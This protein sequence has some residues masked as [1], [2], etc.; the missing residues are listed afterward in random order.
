VHGG[1]LALFSFGS[2]DEGNMNVPPGLADIISVDGSRSGSLALLADGSIVQWGNWPQSPPSN[3]PKVVEI[4]AGWAWA[5]VRLSDGSLRG[6]GANDSG[7]VSGIPSG[8]DF[9]EIATGNMHGLA[10]RA[11]GTVVSWG[12]NDMGQTI[13]PQGLNNVVSISAHGH[14]CVALKS[15]GTVVGWGN[16]NSGINNVPA[17][18][19]NVKA[20]ACGDIFAL[21][22][23]TDGTVVAWGD[24]TEGQTSIPHG[25]KNVAKI[26][27]EGNTAYAILENGSLTS[28]G[29][30]ANE[31]L[32]PPKLPSGY[33]W[34]AIRG[35][36]EH[37]HGL[38]EMTAF[39]I[40]IPPSINGSV[41]GSGEYEPATPATLTAIP[42]PGY[43]FTGWTGDAS[44]TDNPLTITMDADKTV[45]ATF[46][47]DLSDDDG[48]GLSNHDEIV[49]YG[50]NP[51]NP[52]TDGD[53][54]SDGFEVNYPGR[55]FFAVEGSFTHAQA[56]A[57][58]ESRRGRLASFPNLSDYVRAVRLAR[59]TTQ[60]HLWIGLSDEEEEGVWKWLDGS[61]IGYNRWVSGQPDGGTNENHALVAAGTNQWA[62]SVANFVADGYL[63][64]LD[65]LDPLNPDTDGDGLSDGDEVNLHGTDPLNPDSDG[66]GLSDGDEVNIHGTN[67][68]NSDTDGD[69]LSDGDEVNVYGTNPLLKDSDGDGFDDKFEIFTGFDPNSAESTPDA[70][71]TIMTAVEF[72]FNAANGISYRIEVSTDLEDWELL[73]T[74][75][76]G[77]GGV[78]TRFYSIENQS[79]R[80]FRVRRN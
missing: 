52:D 6:W 5:L 79:K 60:G 61:V 53:G 71:S 56:V 32:Q 65:G 41:T 48:D 42:N 27:A 57:D 13:P 10:L 16:G 12:R 15:N 47:K 26:F 34:V 17:G 50:T 76:I 64:E 14:N 31:A 2:N 51:N 23:K 30:R 63:I 20:I 55:R 74:D 54:L 43:R 39:R 21:A 40:S 1:E 49:L 78:V 9:V 73:E 25:L 29:Y 37:M 11:N 19:S 24:N 7:Q 59:Q 28:W 35:G 68:L 45:G 38:A 67:P 75:I 58:A 3:L 36:W 8:N 69:G 46:E 44:G 33:R 4:D 72:R 22:L 70:L 66:D 77:E 62:D 18:L 80:Y